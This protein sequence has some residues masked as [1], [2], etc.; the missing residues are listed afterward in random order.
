[1]K[2]ISTQRMAHTKHHSCK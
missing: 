1:M 2:I